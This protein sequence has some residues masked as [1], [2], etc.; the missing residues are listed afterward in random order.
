MAVDVELLAQVADLVREA[1]LQRVPRVARVLH[2]LGDADARADER[3]VDRLIERDR[4]A[5]VGRVVV[6]DER[7][8]RLP[9]VL[10]RRAFAQELGVDRHA[11]ARRRTSCRTSR[12][13]A[14]IT[15]SCVVPGST[16]L[17]TTTT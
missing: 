3:R 15:T 8:R 6:A 2:H 17:R 11:E 1:H 7:Q 14:G 16:V 10:E 5:G 4:A 12:S 9:E 13:S